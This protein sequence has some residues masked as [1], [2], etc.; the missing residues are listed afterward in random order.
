VIDWRLQPVFRRGNALKS[1]IGLFDRRAIYKGDILSWMCKANLRK[2][3][4]VSQRPRA[5]NVKNELHTR[6]GATTKYESR[7]GSIID[8]SERAVLRHVN[9]HLRWKRGA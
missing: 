6:A 9:D 1:L 5:H 2:V 8:G 7:Y 4:F 3:A